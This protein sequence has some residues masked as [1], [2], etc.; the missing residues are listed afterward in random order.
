MG[1]PKRI[2]RELGLVF[3]PFW[4]GL[5]LKWLHD[6][7][8]WT[9]VGR[10]IVDE[11][12]ENGRSFVCATWHFDLISVLYHF[13]H[14]RGVVMVS[15]SRDGEPIARLVGRWGYEAVRGSKFKG[16][17]DAARQMIDILKRGDGRPA[18]LVADG[19]QGPAR[20]AQTGAVF[21][22]RAAQV[23]IIPT[24]VMAQNKINLKTWDRTQIPWPFTKAAVYFGPPLI[25]P[26][27][28]QGGVLEKHRLELELALNR[29]CAQAENH[30]W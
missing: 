21:I 20:R 22:A 30:P 2:R 6:T 16:G 29:L 23:P 1:E 26:P 24:I 14:R 17:R 15:R 19:S 11:H 10:E 18:G 13:R 25:V 7:C 5:F 12:L 9:F 28:A 4:G 8:R 3:F 27:K